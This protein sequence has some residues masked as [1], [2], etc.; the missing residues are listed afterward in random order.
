MA[1]RE[2]HAG[3]GIEGIVNAPRPLQGEPLRI[4]IAPRVHIGV[5]HLAPE[6]RRALLHR[7]HE[8]RDTERVGQPFELNAVLFFQLE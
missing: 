7:P 8:F 6:M 3:T 2:Q 5:T 4:G 1:S